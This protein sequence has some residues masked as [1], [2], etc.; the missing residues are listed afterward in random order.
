MIFLDIHAMR[1]LYPSTLELLAFDTTARHLSMSRAASELCVTQGAVSRQI[2]Q[3]EHWLGVRLF[4][5]VRQRLVLTDVGKTYLDQIRPSLTALEQATLALR[6]SNPEQ[7]LTLSCVPTFGAKW[8]IPRLPDFKRDHPHITLTFCP[9][10]HGQG[11]VDLSIRYGEGV[12]P[13]MTAD[14]LGGKE[15]SVVFAA[16]MGQLDTPAGVLRHPL[17][18]HASLPHAW[19]QWHTANGLSGSASYA[20]PRFEQFSI[21]IEAVIAGLGVGLVPTCLVE[22]E[23]QLGKM[24]T[25]LSISPPSWKGYYVTQPHSATRHKPA[26]QFH[27]WLLQQAQMTAGQRTGHG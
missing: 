21:L 13:G 19:E 16:G 23:L 10:G 7:G 4:E 22:H 25:L 14:Y 11:T 20:G 5:R 17:L 24:K 26:A 12:W 27:H 15:L 8:L 1:R 6:Q 3:L 18:H 9:Y 2:K